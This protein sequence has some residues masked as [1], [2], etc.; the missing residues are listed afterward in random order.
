MKK[1]SEALRG[2]GRSSIRPAIQEIGS[3]SRMWTSAAMMKASG[4]KGLAM[5]DDYAVAHAG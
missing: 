2:V 5:T 3:M 4:S 1:P